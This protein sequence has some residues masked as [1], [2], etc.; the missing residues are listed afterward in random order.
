MNAWSG[1]CYEGEREENVHVL[2]V[3]QDPRDEVQVFEEV[4]EPHDDFEVVH[5][6]EQLSDFG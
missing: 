4:G 5:F 2:V 3:E 6:F 1:R